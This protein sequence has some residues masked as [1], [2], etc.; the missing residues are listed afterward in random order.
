METSSGYNSSDSSDA[1]EKDEFKNVLMQMMS[2]LR[3]R[4]ASRDS[5]RKF[6]MANASGPGNQTIYGLAQCTLDLSNK[7][8][9]ICLS[10]AF[11]DISK[12]CDGKRGGRVVRPSWYIRF[13]AYS[14]FEA[15]AYNNAQPFV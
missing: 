2:Y 12:C 5:L 7:D 3:E 11:S 8:C 4:A 15:S 14:F 9:D 6:A 13:G 1:L 10:G